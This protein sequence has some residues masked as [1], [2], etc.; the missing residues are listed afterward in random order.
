EARVWQRRHGGNLVQL[1]PYVL[2]AQLGVQR[3]L[4]RMDAYAAKAQSVAAAIT[5]MGNANVAIVPKP[6]QTNMMHVQ[7]R[8][9]NE[10]ILQAALEVSR[11]SDIFAVPRL[12]PTLFPDQFVFEWTVGEATLDIADEEIV[13]LF[14]EMLAS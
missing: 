14:R 6:P 3:H 9:D 11:A 12:Q 4:D 5:A 10:A 1:Y 8:G 2:S 13:G 7:V